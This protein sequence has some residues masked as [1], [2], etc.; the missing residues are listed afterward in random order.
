MPADLVQRLVRAS[1][2]SHGGTQKEREVDPSPC[3]KQQAAE[4]RDSVAAATTVGHQNLRPLFSNER[5]SA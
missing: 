5:Y 2:V 1:W 4:A 3:E